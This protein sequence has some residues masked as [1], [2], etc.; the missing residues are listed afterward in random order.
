GVVVSPGKL[1]LGRRQARAQCVRPLRGAPG[2]GSGVV[3]SNPALLELNI[4]RPHVRL[5]ADDRRIG[6]Q[7][8]CLGVVLLRLRTL[9]PAD[10]LGDVRTQAI[11]GLAQRGRLSLRRIEPLAQSIRALLLVDGRSFRTVDPRSLR[12]DTCL[13]SAGPFLRASDGAL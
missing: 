11:N 5:E 10:G 8:A 7:G 2:L 1:A 12:L 4:L 6:L 13:G 3:S 9:G